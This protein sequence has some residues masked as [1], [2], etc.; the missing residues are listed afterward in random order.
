MGLRI[1]TNELSLS[2]QRNL[3][4]TD[5]RMHSVVERLSSG[6][7]I[8]KASDDP[9]GLSISD[10]LNAQVRS[11]GQA[12]RNAQDGISLVQV[13]EGGTNEINN[14]LV[15]MRELAMQ[16]A[17]D[18]VGD[19]ERVMIDNEVQQLKMEIDRVAKS[20][21]YASRDLLSGEKVKLDFQV[22]I[23]NEDEVDRITF[24]PGNTN[25][26]S[27][28]IDVDGL[29]VADKD[30]AQSALATVDEALVKVNDIRSRIGSIQGR[31][32]STQ[33]AQSIFQENLSAARSRIKD[34]DI[35]QESAN[36]ARE[37]IL[38][39]AGVSVLAQ[40]NQT[41]YLALSLLK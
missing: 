38:R 29:S 26:T 28:G 4:Q 41:P 16:S 7:R 36:L 11:L 19:K 31:L 25:L 21:K 10:A 1:N 6:S 14:M 2:A 33:V 39:Q 3:E 8:T 15:R 13:Y 34:A 32:N 18:T 37:S 24:D 5:R 20:T 23:N 17:T 35:A 22:G 27:S 30:G 40:A 9:A 12:I